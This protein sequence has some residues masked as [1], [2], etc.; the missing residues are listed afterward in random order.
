MTQGNKKLSSNTF[1]NLL[2]KVLALGFAA[3][4]AGC[5]SGPQYAKEM[6][7]D[8]ACISDDYSIWN[9][10]T[11]PTQGM[12][13]FIEIDGAPLKSGDR[14]V[15]VSAGKHKFKTTVTTD[16][17][18]NEGVIELDL[19]PNTT[20]W[21]RAK[22]NGSWGFGNAFDFQLLDVTDKKQD[23]VYTFSVDAKTRSFEM[24]ISPNGTPITIAR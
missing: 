20:Y 21:L 5:A 16:F 11:S 8:Q 23:V 10:L 6:R 4:T 18:S 13:R 22:L 24:F 1:S 7:S 3:F 9:D 17:R 19:K 12:L 2:L 14:P 15:C